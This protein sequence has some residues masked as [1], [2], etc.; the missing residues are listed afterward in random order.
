MFRS[1]IFT[2]GKST[3]GWQVLLCLALLAFLCRSVIP[4]GYMP[5]LAAGSG[6][7]VELTLCNAQGGTQTIV[8]DL[9]N[10]NKEPADHAGQECPFGLVLSQG[11][12][13]AHTTLLLNATV[14]QQRP[15]L[16]ADRTRPLPPLPALGPPIGPRAPPISLG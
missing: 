5:T 3:I 4:A 7:G 9:Q 13:A 1:S 15:V 8:L 16:L 2:Q 11:V 10:K 6:T 14:W 12:L